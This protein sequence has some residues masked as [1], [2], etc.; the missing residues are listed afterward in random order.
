V[1]GG[2]IVVS[3]AVDGGWLVRD[4]RAGRTWAA[5]DQGLERRMLELLGETVHEGLALRARLEA[6]CALPLHR[7]ATITGLVVR[8]AGP[9]SRATWVEPGDLPPPAE[10]RIR[11]DQDGWAF[12]GEAFGQRS[13]SIPVAGQLPAS[14]TAG[15]LEALSD[16]SRCP[17]SELGE[18]VPRPLTDRWELQLVVQLDDDRSVVAELAG[19]AWRLYLDSWQGEQRGAALR[20]ALEPLRSAVAAAAG[21]Q[22]RP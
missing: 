16:G 18:G 15:L 11:P 4:E 17:V 5:A 3:Q 12:E 20:S 14:T 22:L 19:P 21:A 10:V 1:R 2:E 13:E 6:P 7:D 8:D 9:R